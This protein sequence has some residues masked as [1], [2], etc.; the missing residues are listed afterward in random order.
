MEAPQNLFLD[1]DLTIVDSITAFCKA[2]N[3]LYKN[4]KGFEVAD[5]TKLISY[6]FS[7]ICP[8]IKT[9]EQKMEIW[10]SKELFDNLEF[11]ENA[12]EVM[13][14]KSQEYKIIICSIGTFENVARKAMLIDNRMPFVHDCILLTNKD[15]KMDKSYVNMK[16]GIFVDDIVSNLESTN[17]EFKILFGE[18]R[19][20]NPDWKGLTA[21]NWQRLM[22]I[23]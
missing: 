19:P 21:L 7:C 12:Y 18:K 4:E 17:A 5:P 2:Y 1:F 20:W 6:D 16:N 14:I 8:L 15:C 22:S 3:I 11:M 9:K 10:G 13:L 23:L